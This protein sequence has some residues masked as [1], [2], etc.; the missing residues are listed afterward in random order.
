MKDSCACRSPQVHV[1]GQGRV[2][3]GYAGPG[4]LVRG[5]AGLGAEGSLQALLMTPDK[6]LDGYPAVTL[7][8]AASGRFRDGMAVSGA[9]T[10]VD[11]LVRVYGEDQGFLG[12]GEIAW[13]STGHVLK[14][15]SNCQ[16]IVGTD[17]ARR[18]GGSRGSGPRCGASR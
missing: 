1:A 3:L 11:G 14:A 18:P 5:E 9:A 17:P 10:G 4:D 2:A 12:L 7:D 13:K 8:G 15:T 16:M 6:A